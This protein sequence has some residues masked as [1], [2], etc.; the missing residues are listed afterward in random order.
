MD[1]S[2]LT[3]IIIVLIGTFVTF[4]LSLLAFKLQKKR[5]KLTWRKLSNI[6]IPANQLT[7]VNW[8]IEN[9]GNQYAKD[10]NV[11]V[12]LPNEATFRTLDCVS[13]EIALEYTNIL[14]EANNEVKIHIPIFPQNIS[15]D[16]SSLIKNFSNEI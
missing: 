3:K 14:N 2:I 7:G 4:L 9:I 6:K 15:L 13:S 10:V 16:I 1:N 11:I 8:L 5:P 12:K